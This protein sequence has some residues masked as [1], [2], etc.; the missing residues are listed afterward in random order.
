M[1]RRFA[2]ATA[3]AI[4]S[5]LPAMPAAAFDVPL[6][7]AGLWEIKMEFVGRKIPGQVIRQCVDAAT[8]Q[9]MNSSFGG[10]MQEACSKRDMHTVAGV[11]TIDSVC[12]FG[13]ATTTS[14]AVV[15][16]S[17]DSAYTVD[18]TSTRSG[19]RPIPGMAQGGASHMKIAGRWLGPCA[20]GQR[21]GDMI[22]ANG[23]KINVLDMPH[24]P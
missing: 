8:D 12:K 16:G 23:M 13:E 15:S 4:V 2:A 22:M 19:G 24:R 14:H 11:M 3:I 7:K 10:S 6:R 18:V 1:S 20:A 9:K 17:F 5:A 21:P